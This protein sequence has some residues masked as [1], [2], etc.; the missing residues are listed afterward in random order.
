V[1]REILDIIVGIVLSEG[2]GGVVLDIYRHFRGGG[3]GRSSTLL[4]RGLA[5][6]R[7]ALTRNGLRRIRDL[8]TMIDGGKRLR[9]LR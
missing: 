7:Q 3:R 5:Y 2:V 4:H 9:M 6:E 8:A 1:G